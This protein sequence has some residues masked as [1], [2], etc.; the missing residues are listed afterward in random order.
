MPVLGRE[1]PIELF[2]VLAMV[3]IALYSGKKRT[4]KKAAQWAFYLFYPV[5]LGVL[6]LIR[7]L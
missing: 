7:V 2:G 1:I 4:H 3:P 6:Y 5:H